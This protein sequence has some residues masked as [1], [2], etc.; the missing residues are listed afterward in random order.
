MIGFA[1]YIV[2]FVR[3]MGWHGTRVLWSA[4]RGVKQT[5]GGVYDDGARQWARGMLRGCHVTVDVQGREHL[6]PGTSRVYISN[7]TSFIDIWAIVAEFPGTIRFVYKK[8]MNWI[9]LMGQAMRAARHIP[10]DRKNR[11]ATFAAYDDAAKYLQDGTSAVIFPE[12]TRSR[13]GRLKP[14][15]KGSFVLA[16]A[17]QVP[18]VPV[19]CENAYELMPRGSWSPKPGVVTLKIGAPI[20]TTGLTIDARDDL[21]RRCREALLALGAR[22]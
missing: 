22:E 15:K 8:G 17:A 7:H 16:I 1:R 10:I 18:V 5:P 13:D 14:L 12:G 21:A 19:L 6:D 2:S 3:Y 20:P 11:S 9:P 4:L